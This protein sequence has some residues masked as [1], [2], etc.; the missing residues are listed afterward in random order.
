[1]T[2]PGSHKHYLP[3]PGLHHLDHCHNNNKPS[4]RRLLWDTEGGR[5]LTESG[6]SLLL[7]QEASCDNVL[8]GPNEHCNKGCCV[9]D[10]GYERD[11]LGRCVYTGNYNPTL[12]PEPPPEPP[13]NVDFKL[14]QENNG[15]IFLDGTSGITILTYDPSDS[16]TDPCGNVICGPNSSCVDGTCRC[17]PGYQENEDGI[18]VPIPNPGPGPGPIEPPV[19]FEKIL[20]DNGST[21]VSGSM[22]YI[23]N[24]ADILNILRYDGSDDVDD[25]C[26]AINCGDNSTCDN[27]ICVC[28]PGFEPNEN[29][30][31]V[32]IIVPPDEDASIRNTTSVSEYEVSDTYGFQ[33]LYTGLEEVDEYTWYTRPATSTIYNYDQ[34]RSRPAPKDQTFADIIFDQAGTYT[35]FCTLSVGG[36]FINAQKVVEV[37]ETT[38]IRSVVIETPSFYE[39]LKIGTTYDLVAFT[40]GNPV[41]PQYQWEIP[42]TATG[43]NLN[44]STGQIIF[45]SALNDTEKIYCTVTDA[46]SSDS[47][48]RRGVQVFTA[49]IRILQESTGL[50]FVDDLQTNSNS[51]NIG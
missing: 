23:D 39:T 44:K 49:G 48:V 31:C 16:P 7:F 8:C 46:S 42:S 27:G 40:T 51:I 47:P 12:P 5:I 38:K 9:C 45:N 22:I 33:V 26:Y 43:T 25:P 36:Q 15:I 21:D 34:I 41:N 24:Q 6:Y 29:G 10:L 2:R 14:L 35:I 20:Q 1:M 11:S 37:I 3:H 19:V 28:N 18:C 30:V 32:P 4:D 17:F 50:I 13:L